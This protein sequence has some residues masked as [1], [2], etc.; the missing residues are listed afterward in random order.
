[1]PLARCLAAIDGTIGAMQI[2]LVF[3]LVHILAVISAVGANATYQFWY[4]RAG[5]DSARLVWV[6]ESIRIL[7]R[8]VANPSYIVALLAGIATVITGSFSFQSL[9]IGASIGLYVLVAVLGIALYAPAMR[10][11]QA[12][13]AADPTSSDYEAAAK[14]SR[15]LGGLATGLVF[16]IVMLMVFKPTL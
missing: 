15:M 3:K 2:W 10:R 16:V 6:I 5:R 14:R 4:S 12:L 13:A 7:D 8:R 9:W 11:Q 1:M